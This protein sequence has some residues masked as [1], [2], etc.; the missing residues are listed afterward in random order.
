MEMTPLTPGAFHD[1][2][3]SGYST[4]LC[5]AVW[6][7]FVNGKRICGTP[8]EFCVRLNK[9]EDEVFR[10]ILRAKWDTNKGYWVKVDKGKVTKREALNYL[11]G[12]LPQ[13]V[14]KRKLE[15]N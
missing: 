4:G 6:K 14:L 12:E 8:Q 11:E 9:Q 13:W 1:Y 2:L 10:L 5:H 3:Q 7:L 15:G